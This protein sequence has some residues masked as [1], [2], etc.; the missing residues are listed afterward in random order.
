M[1]ETLHIHGWRRV[2]M[3]K[4]NYYICC[5]SPNCYLTRQWVDIKHKYALCPICF[6]RF[7]ILG[8]Q[9]GKAVL[10]CHAC[11]KHE[12]TL[13][14]IRALEK[15]EIEGEKNEYLKMMMCRDIPVDPAIEES[16]RPKVPKKVAD[17]LI[18]DMMD[19]PDKPLGDKEELPEF[20]DIAI[21]ASSSLTV[22]QEEELKQ[23]LEIKLRKLV[24]NG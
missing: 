9:V 2:S 5:A 1:I 18:Q 8:Y 19:T 21:P 23:A 11:S 17:F 4:K 3:S 14:E 6:E 7:I 24:S 13:V 20:V 12:L 10:E 22:E 16:P 15:L